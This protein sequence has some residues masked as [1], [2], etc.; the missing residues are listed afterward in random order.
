MLRAGVG[1]GCEDRWVGVV[2]VEGRQVPGLLQ[3]WWGAIKRSVPTSNFKR[4]PQLLAESL[5]LVVLRLARN[6]LREH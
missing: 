4:D 5:A 1:G 3:T 2:V 6:S